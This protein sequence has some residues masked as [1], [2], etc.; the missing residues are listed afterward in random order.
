MKFKITKQYPNAPSEAIAKFTKKA[1]ALMFVNSVIDW[2][3]SVGAVNVM[4]RLYEESQLINEFYVDV[5][6]Q[7]P[8]Q[9]PR[10]SPTPLPT[11][12]HL[13]GMPGMRRIDEEDEDF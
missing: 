11:S 1:D 5:H 10:Y 4:Y 3:K 8:G 9:G 7:G 12:P 2:D 13:P 6:N